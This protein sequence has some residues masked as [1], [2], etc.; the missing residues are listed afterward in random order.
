M[1]QMYRL[2]FCDLDRMSGDVLPL[3]ELRQRIIDTG[4]DPRHVSIQQRSTPTGPWRDYDV[5]AM[6][7]RLGRLFG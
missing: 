4:A 7:D 6:L 3:L 5:E 2:V 1:Y